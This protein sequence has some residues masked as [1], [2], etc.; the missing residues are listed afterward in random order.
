MVVAVTVRPVDPADLRAIITLDG[1]AFGFTYIESDHE[2]IATF[3]E[4]D[5]TLVAA[6]GAEVVGTTSASSWRSE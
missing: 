3:L 6:D 5:R 1:R 2:D 4:L